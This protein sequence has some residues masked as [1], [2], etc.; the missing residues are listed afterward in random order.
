[1]TMQKTKILKELEEEF[2]I[3]KKELKL[4]SSLD[5]LDKA[6]FIRDFILREGHMSNNLADSICCGMMNIYSSW[7]NYLHGLIIPNHN[8]MSLIKESGIFSEEDKEHFSKLID[9]IMALVST[10]VLIR[11]T[12]D[13][14]KQTKFIDD[15]L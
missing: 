14:T 3:I 12:K 9:H 10:H 11:L 5:E 13:K 1:M 4:K 2:E 15:S 7:S 8:N 6:F